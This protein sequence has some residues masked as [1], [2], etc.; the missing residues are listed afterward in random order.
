MTHVY[1]KRKWVTSWWVNKPYSHNTLE[2]EMRWPRNK[3]TWITDAK[4]TYVDSGRKILRWLTGCELSNA[5]R[6]DFKSSHVQMSAESRL[7]VKMKSSPVNPIFIHKLF[8]SFP[9]SST[10]YE[11]SRRNKEN[12]LYFLYTSVRHFFLLL[13]SS[14]AVCKLQGRKWGAVYN[15]DSVSF[16]RLLF[17]KHVRVFSSE[18]LP[19]CLVKYP[20]SC[21][22]SHFCFLYNMFG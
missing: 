8:D 20:H 11:A 10:P 16:L 7:T 22:S 14:T 21:F 13:F 18:N 3:A 1:G 12:K 2:W 9:L 15:R 5:S 6:Y 19:F 4:S 17:G